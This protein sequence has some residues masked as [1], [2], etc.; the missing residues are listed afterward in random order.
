MARM[1]DFQEF[2]THNGRMDTGFIGDIFTWCNNRKG[3]QRIW[4]RLDRV[5]CNLQAHNIFPCLS[6]HHLDRSSSDHTPLWINFTDLQQTGKR[7]F[8]FQRM[9]LDHLSFR[10]MWFEKIGAI[11]GVARLGSASEAETPK[12]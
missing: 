5:L 1:F 11:L 8:I 10:E 4:Q 7:P 2:I 6:I 12:I 9:W 3:A